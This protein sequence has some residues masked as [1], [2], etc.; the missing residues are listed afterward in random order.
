AAARGGCDPVDPDEP[1][2]KAAADARPGDAARHR[3]CRLAR[4]AE[5]ETHARGVRHYPAA[6]RYRAAHLSLAAL[7]QRSVRPADRLMEIVSTA[8]WTEAGKS[9]A[10]IEGKTHGRW[11]RCCSSTCRPAADRVC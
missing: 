7:A 4:S 3:Q 9:G 6:A 11:S 10:E 5:R 1:A 8:Q 2:A